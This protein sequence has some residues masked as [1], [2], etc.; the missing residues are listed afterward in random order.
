MLLKKKIMPEYITD[1]TEI[2]PDSDRKDPDEENSNEQN[3]DEEN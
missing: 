2:S 3:S 1:D